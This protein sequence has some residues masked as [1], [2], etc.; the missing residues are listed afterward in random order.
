MITTTRGW[1]TLA[2]ALTLPP[3]AHAMT[4]RE[5]LVFHVPALKSDADMKAF[6]QYVLQELIPAWKTKAPDMPLHLVRA[7]R[8]N[9][10]G[11]YVLVWTLGVPASGA[12]SPAASP[13]AK[14]ASLMGDFQ[15]G[16]GR[17]VDGR[18]A[19]AEYQLL[20]PQTAGSLPQVDVLGMHFVKVKPERRDSFEA[21][22]RDT[23]HPAVANLRPDL[24]VLYYRS[25]P[26]DASNYVALFALTV[27]SRDKYWPGGSDS[28]D[29]RAAFKPVQ[30]LTK[31]LATYLVEGSYLA[32]PK[33][34]AAVYESRE[35]ADFVE[36]AAGR[37]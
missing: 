26:G 22:V 7:D 14:V 32:D 27:Q 23:I 24:R 10:K 29:L 2:L 4:L 20:S 6:E 13:S 11:Q 21:Y 18:G 9:R 15:P 12:T 19:Y 33:F 3:T 36:V 37:R 17:F 34:A 16:I 1:L 8:G 30:P 25:T 31:E 28:D 35:W 5:V